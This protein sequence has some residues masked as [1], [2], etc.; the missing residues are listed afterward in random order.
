MSPR[1]RGV[2]RRQTSGITATAPKA[3][4]K[5]LP[6]A[7]LSELSTVVDRLAEH[8]AWM[9]AA[10]QALDEALAGDP[11]AW[12][13]ANAYTQLASELAQDSAVIQGQSGLRAAEL[14]R[15]TI[16]AYVALQRK[17]A[18]ALTLAASRAQSVRLWLEK[19]GLMDGGKLRPVVASYRSLLSSAGRIAKRMAANRAWR[20]RREEKRAPDLSQ[21]AIEIA[22]EEN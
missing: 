18:A 16:H 3:V 15:M 20:E 5:V 13:L 14:G 17:Q 1:Q 11:D 22:M 10:L 7:K 21:R 2:M 12:P 9:A 6:K 8:A 19:E 4:V